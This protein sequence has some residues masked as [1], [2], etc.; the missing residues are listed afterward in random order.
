MAEV[1]YHSVLTLPLLQRFIAR[2]FSKNIVVVSIGLKTSI[3][4]LIFF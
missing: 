3:F 4:W 1:L 2:P